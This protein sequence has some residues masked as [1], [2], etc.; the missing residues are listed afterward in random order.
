MVDPDCA[1]IIS[2]HQVPTVPFVSHLMKGWGVRVAEVC[3]GAGGLS[4]GLKN[5]GFTIKRVIDSSQETL[6]VYLRNLGTRS[7]L[8]R[9]P[10]RYR[11]MNGDLADLLSLAPWIISANVDMLAGGPPCQDFSSA[12]NRIE[13]TRADLTLA[14]A[15]LIAIVRPRWLLMENVPDA[16]KSMAWEG[17]RRVL[18][19][20]G[21]GLD[22]R[23]LNVSLFGVPQAR[24]RFIVVGRLDEEDGFLGSAIE[25]A[26]ANRP[27]TVRDVLGDDV[28]VHPG[29]S[30]PP[31]TRVFF[32]RPYTGGRGV[33]SIDEPSPTVIRT[34]GERAGPAYRA[35]PGDLAPAQ[36]VKPLT[37]AQ[38]SLIQGFPSAWD[39]TAAK[40]LRARAQMIANAVPPPFAEA[41]GNVIL[42][43]DRGES[44]P[45][46]EPGFSAW[47]KDEKGLSGGTLRNRRSQVNRARKLLL[48]RMLADPDLEAMLLQ[49]TKNFMTLAPTTRSDLLAALRLHAEWREAQKTAPTPQEVDPGWDPFADEERNEDGDISRR[50]RIGRNREAPEM[51]EPDE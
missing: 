43:R 37:M 7:R 18:K 1:G 17:A 19:R 44:I 39:W 13:G 26:T 4:L 33:R 15:M 25:A 49:R 51:S 23:E 50:L 48:G 30:H 14:Y 40:T 8:V 3:C 27:T 2:L 11:V 32:M 38:L 10:D 5:A 31:A 6:A 24:H 20:T 46:L 41:I 21:Y 47:L 16:A 34:S 42:A 35:H 45:K 29:G 12:G 36:H 22:E 9:A 28:G